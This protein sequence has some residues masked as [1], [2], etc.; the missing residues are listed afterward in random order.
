MDIPA[1]FTNEYNLTQFA[2]NGWV[3]FEITKGVYSL[4]QASKLANDLLTEWLHT[5]GYFQSDITPGLWRH[6]WRPIS[7]VLIVDDFGIKFV[8]VNV[9]PITYYMHSKHTTRSQQ[10]G[11]APNLPAL[12]LPGTTLSA[13]VTYQCK[14]TLM[15]FS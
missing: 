15:I 6:K 12:T 1:E 8:L 14:T 4:K 13:R 10:T 9:M 7:F 11:R 3:Y 2:H 5:F